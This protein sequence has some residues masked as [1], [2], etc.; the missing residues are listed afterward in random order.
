MGKRL[1]IVVPFLLPHLDPVW[2]KNN[3]GRYRENK[4]KSYEYLHQT[5]PESFQMRKPFAWFS[6]LILFL[7]SIFLYSFQSAKK[8]DGIAGNLQIESGLIS[9]IKSEN[10]AVIAYKGIPFAAP[11]VGDLRWKKPQP[12]AP[13]PG[14]K[15]CDAFGPSPMQGKPVPFMVYTKEFLI[16]EKPISEDCLYLNVWTKAKKGEKR[17]VF[18]WIYGGGFVSGG[19]AV[20]IY[21]GE[22]LANKGIIFVSVN[23]RVGVFGFL[24]LSE[25]SKESPDKASGNYGILDQIAALQWIKKNIDAFGGDPDNITI[26]GQ[27]AGSMIVNCLVASPVAKGLFNK[28]I[29]ESGSMLI[30]KPMTLSAAEQQGD[31]LLNSVHA[32]SLIELR[33]LAAEDLMK[34]SGVFWPIVDGYVL[35]KPVSE[36]FTAG[37]ENHVPVITGWNADESFVFGFKNKEAFQKEVREKYGTDADQFLKYYPANTDEEAKR[38]QIRL[39]RDMIFALSG[40]KW[41]GLQSSEGKAP[42]YVYYFSRKLPAT[43]EY[44]K[45]GAFHTGEV[46]YVMDNLKFLHRPWESS[47]A[48]LAALMSAYWVNF[49]N[50]GNPNG[51][52]LPDWPTYNTTN[53][54]AIV[55]DTVS[56][57]QTLPD[58]AALEFMLKR[59]GN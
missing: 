2:K 39:S 44:V 55:L 17:P 47:D 20:P 41:A 24:A 42:V 23:Y 29:S 26:A 4:M 25:L 38:S 48:S 58:Q 32:S 33:K 14:I 43:A 3:N 31:K 10:S 27:S 5:I 35:P 53:F 30:S 51:K 50:N 49:I 16:P 34:F 57:K 6:C 13:W 37:Q 8:T 22:S 36:I 40:Y 21:D 15:K 19:T 28:A 18:I 12:V 56:G 59:P 54:Q 46:A 7:T 52:G 1:S 11:P 45:Y 9:G